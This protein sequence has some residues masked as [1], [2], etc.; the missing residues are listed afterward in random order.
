MTVERRRVR[1][2]EPDGPQLRRLRAR[3]ERRGESPSQR[4]QQEAAAVHYSMT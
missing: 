3:N 4:G 2:Q 1:A